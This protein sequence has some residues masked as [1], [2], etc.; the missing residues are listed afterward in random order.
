MRERAGLGSSQGAGQACILGSNLMQPIDS[1]VKDLLSHVEHET[2]LRGLRLSSELRRLER[3]DHAQT[4]ERINHVIDTPA[5]STY[6]RHLISLSLLVSS[7][8]SETR[9]PSPSIRIAG[10]GLSGLVLGQCLRQKG[11][12]F[13]IWERVKSNPTRNNYGITLY[14]STYRPLLETLRITEDEFTRQVGVHHPDSGAAVSDNQRLRVN[15]SALTRLLEAG[16][17]IQWNHKLRKPIL[18][19]AP[20]SVSIWTGEEEVTETFDLL[21]AADGVHSAARTQL[22]LPSSAFELEVLPYVVFNGKRRMQCSNL[23][24]GLLDCFTSPDGIT[25]SHD[26]TV[27]SIKA[28]F[29]DSENQTVAV[30]YTLSRAASEGD[31]SLLSRNISDAEE[32]SKLFIE[33]VAAL[34][35]LPA[36][37]GQIFNPSTMPEDRLLHWLMR[38]SLINDETIKDAASNKGILLL[39]D[40]AHAQ[41]IPGNGGNLAIDDA[42]EAARHVSETGSFDVDAFLQARSAAW[43]DGK[44]ENERALEV[45][46]PGSKPTARI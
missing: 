29:W 13:T 22:D 40:A 41:P 28:D 37:F 43:I 4:K 34:G 27:L 6:N 20:Q 33:E 24:T 45:L 44:R 32:R 42:V 12:Q 31:Q 16:L 21:V 3:H 19:D 35:E 11:I 39:G 1:R 30:S 18:D 23:P 15:R 25:H 38:S 8:M 26:G 2:R 46:H 17:D 10:A 7:V 14:K 5:T 9:M 36:P